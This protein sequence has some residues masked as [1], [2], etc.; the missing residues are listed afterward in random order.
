MTLDAYTEVIGGFAPNSVVTIEGTGSKTMAFVPITGFAF[1][2]SLVSPVLAGDS[3]ERLATTL[4]EASSMTIRETATKGGPGVTTRDEQ[5]LV[6]DTGFEESLHFSQR[7]IE[8]SPSLRISVESSVLSA[9]KPFA[10][11]VTSAP[12]V[13]S[14]GVTTRAG[15]VSTEI[16][17]PLGALSP[18]VHSVRLL[19]KRDIDTVTTDSRGQLTLSPKAKALLAEF[20]AGTDATIRLIGTKADGAPRTVVMFVPLPD[21]FPWWLIALVA[22]ALGLCAG[23][24]V[25]RRRTQGTGTA[26]FSVLTFGLGISGVAVAWLVANSAAVEATV[27]MACVGLLGAV[28]ARF[29]PPARITQSSIAAAKASTPRPLI[30][31][32]IA[33]RST[34][35]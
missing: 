1:I 23:G 26:A 17:I 25:W 27:L 7:E 10:T 35:N 2:D 5:F 15:S 3:S 8:N 14:S 34:S 12:R 11:I 18:G 4:A 21:A 9:G 24:A 16:S 32:L 13:I 29:V 20:D 30:D 6:T 19:G 22:I 31:K 33:G 28:L